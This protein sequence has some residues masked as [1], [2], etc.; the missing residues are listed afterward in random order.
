MEGYFCSPYLFL[1]GITDFWLPIHLS[2]GVTL[3]RAK[4]L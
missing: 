2:V 4:R 1:V 3:T